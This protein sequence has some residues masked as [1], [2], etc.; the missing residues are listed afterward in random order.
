MT[1]KVTREFDSPIWMGTLSSHPFPTVAAERRLGVLV[2]AI[3]WRVLT[4]RRPVTLDPLTLYA[5]RVVKAGFEET[6]EYQKAWPKDLQALAV[7]VRRRLVSRGLLT[8]AG[9]LSPSASALLEGVGEET[10]EMSWAFQDPFTGEMMPRFQ[11]GSF[12][13]PECILESG[14]LSIRGGTEGRPEVIHRP[15]DIRFPRNTPRPPDNRA[16]ETAWKLYRKVDRGARD[17][18]PRLAKATEPLRVRLVAFLFQSK[19]ASTWFVCDP[20][21]EGVADW[22]KDSLKMRMAAGE[23]GNLAKRI[24]AFLKC[25]PDSLEDYKSS[26]GGERVRDLIGMHPEGEMGRELALAVS[27]M[28]SCP[29][30]DDQDQSPIPSG[31]QKNL[32][33]TA[34]RLFSA[35]E[36]ALAAVYKHSPLKTGWK[37]FS[38]SDHENAESAVAQMEQ[39]G[40]EMGDG[41]LTRRLLA[42]KKGALRAVHD[43]GDAALTPL[44]VLLLHAR[45]SS[46]AHPFRRAAAPTIRQ[47]LELKILRD[48]R[49]H[50]ESAGWTRADSARLAGIF[51]GMVELLRDVVVPIFSKSSASV[52]P[53]TSREPSQE[54]PAPDSAAA[55]AFR[56]EQRLGTVVWE[57]SPIELRDRLV[58][59]LMKG[60][61][62]MS[63]EGDER[64]L[65]WTEFLVEAGGWCETVLKDALSRTDHRSL[66]SFPTGDDPG[67]FSRA[68]SLEYTVDADFDD[69]TRH[70][71]TMRNATIGARKPRHA[72]LSDLTAAAI[73]CCEM[74]QI[75]PLRKLPKACPDALGFLAEL[76]EQRGHGHLSA[77]S[78]VELPNR[79]QQFAEATLKLLYTEA[80]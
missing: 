58:T 43:E 62:A 48:P 5:L 46:A 77:T 72:T 63:C 75:Q 41:A 16:L 60:H 23:A 74:D 56:L 53:A 65:A 15:E 71:L 50:G 9:G 24:S 37:Q 8:K 40:F 78:A 45:T 20:I 47:L 1:D 42:V 49:S 30:Q 54:A 13:E 61:Q 14:G 22:L 11:S 51:E 80:Q 18:A 66:V 12:D 70:W 73:L 26:E 34:Q 36:H 17:G 21:T 68:T 67:L 29:K 52:Q 69:R 35:M 31:Q 39:A 4:P 19:D 33:R 59:T 25:E 7:G 57:R 3:A 64:A 32:T 38:R 55:L 2:P 76:I 6:G 27:A 79:L 28:Q 10:F 44:I